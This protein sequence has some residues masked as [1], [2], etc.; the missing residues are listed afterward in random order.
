MFI[1]LNSFTAPPRPNAVQTFLEKRTKSFVVVRHFVPD[2]G[3]KVKLIEF[4][5]LQVK[6]L[7]YSAKIATYSQQDMNHI[8]L[9][10]LVV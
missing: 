7:H 2:V 6:L 8:C 10:R 9:I 4:K 3:V 5:S 1:A